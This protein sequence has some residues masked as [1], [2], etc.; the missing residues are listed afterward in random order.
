MGAVSRAT[1]RKATAAKDLRGDDIERFIPKIDEGYR[2]STARE[3]WPLSSAS[4]RGPAS[5]FSEAGAS[6]R[7][8]NGENCKG[9]RTRSRT[10][11]RGQAS[12]ELI[13]IGLKLLPHRSHTYMI[14]QCAPPEVPAGALQFRRNSLLVKLSGLGASQTS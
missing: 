12:G 9:T 11:H 2:R 3:S 4:S 8:K 14:R 6:S 1:A 7:P 13:L 10:R 5:A